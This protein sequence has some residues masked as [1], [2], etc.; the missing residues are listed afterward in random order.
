VHELAVSQSILNLVADVARQHGGL[1][2]KVVVLIG[3]LSGVEPASLARAYPIAAA[4]T[5][6]DGSEL[7]IETADVVVRCRGCGA[8]TPTSPNRLVCGTCG[9]WH[10]DLT[11]GN[12]LLLLRVEL[13]QPDP[14]HTYDEQEA[15]ANV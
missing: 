4:G 15:D 9:D 1:V 3:P 6:A 2:Q 14:V 8:S 11:G 12:E 10:T 13:T 5:V 7:V